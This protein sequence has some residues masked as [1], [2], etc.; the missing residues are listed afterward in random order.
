MRQVNIL[1]LSKALQQLREQ[2]LNSFECYL[3]ADKL[4]IPLK[5]GMNLPVWELGHLAWFQEYWIARNL[6]RSQGLASSS[7]KQRKYA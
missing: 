3:S 7:S 1:T 2:T 6:E 4:T 5:T